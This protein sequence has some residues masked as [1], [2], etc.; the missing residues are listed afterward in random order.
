MQ[1]SH[2][3]VVVLTTA[4]SKTLGSLSSSSTP[5]ITPLRVGRSQFSILKFSNNSCSSHS[6]YHFWNNGEPISPVR[7]NKEPILGGIPNFLSLSLRRGSNTTAMEVTSKLFNTSAS[8]PRAQISD[9]ESLANSGAFLIPRLFSI[10]PSVKNKRA[11]QRSAFSSFASS[12]SSAAFEK[13]DV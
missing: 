2:G 5:M 3:R 6:L 4:R 9:R 10:R 12:K 8:P 11:L 7:A 13:A 1:S